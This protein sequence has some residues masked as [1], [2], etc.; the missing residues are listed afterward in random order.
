MNINL[1]CN[2]VESLIYKVNDKTKINLIFDKG[3]LVEIK[4][5]ADPKDKSGLFSNQQLERSLDIMKA[6]ETPKNSDS[7]NKPKPY[8]EEFITSCNGPHV[9]TKKPSPSLSYELSKFENDDTHET[10]NA[11]AE[12]ETQLDKLKEDRKKAIKRALAD[13]EENEIYVGK[14]GEYALEGI[15]KQIDSQTD[16]KPDTEKC[17]KTDEPKVCVNKKEVS[18]KDSKKKTTKKETKGLRNA[19]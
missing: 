13:V 12:K 7:L 10:D 16:V 3:S 2:N 17:D 11:T 18:L 1:D 5:H 4:E 14:L 8:N 9:C 19:D 15:K 6:I